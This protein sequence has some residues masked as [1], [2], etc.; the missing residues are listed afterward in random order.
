MDRVKEM[1]MVMLMKTITAVMVPP[2]A[3]RRHRERGGE[4]PTLCLLL[5]GLPLDGERFSL[6]ILAFM[7]MIAPSGFFPM[8]S[9]DDVP[10]RQGAREVLD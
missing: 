3:L 5:H 8:A 7:A 9:G 10:L 2:M 1:R 4:D 6:W